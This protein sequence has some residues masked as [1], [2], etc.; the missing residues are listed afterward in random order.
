[1]TSSQSNPD[2]NLPEFLSGSFLPSPPEIMQKIRIAT[3][4]LDKIAKIIN[5]DMGLC[6]SVLKTINSPFYG[7]KNKI[8]SIPQAVA[9]LGL[10]SVMNI[11]NAH[12]LLSVLKSADYNSELDDFWQLSND[13]A[14][15]CVTVAN[16][17]N[18]TAL[19][20]IYLLGLFHDAGI[21]MML[22]R[23]PDY[24]TKIQEAYEQSEIRITDIENNDYNCNH[25]V[26]GY[27]IA[28]SWQ[29]PQ[30]FRTTIRD[31]HNTDHLTY[32]LT[33]ENYTNTMM[34]I[35]KI[36][37]HISRTY[38]IL[39]HQ[40]IDHEWMK[41]KPSILV[42]LG[43]SEPDFEELEDYVYDTMGLVMD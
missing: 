12:L 9:L 10:D 25:A 38:Q 23:F 39:G 13:I 21:P 34:V 27:L 16:Y 37:E 41:I 2:E 14:E 20:D 8:I 36:S 4:D 17:L 29:L 28:K 22:K 6:A 24:M 19:D 32:G 33:E 42:Y 40:E 30:H 43:F 5:T 3:P 15:T 11:I 7:L 26:V 18:F 31:H 35:L 1:M